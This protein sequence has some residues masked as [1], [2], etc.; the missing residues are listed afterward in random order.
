[1]KNFLKNLIALFL[2]CVLALVSIEI[3]LK[4][5]NP[6]ET[7]I[8]GNKIIL[9][10]NKNYR[11]ENQRL[12]KLDRVIIHSKNSLGF[13]GTEPPDEFNKYLTIICIGGSTTE[14]QYL[15]DNKTWIDVLSP[16][17]TLVLTVISI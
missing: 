10:I 2:G 9:P 6:I 11:I 12:D 14:Y 8:R 16:I 17:F 1:M 5:Y 7:R 4:I 3:V 13:R 15:S